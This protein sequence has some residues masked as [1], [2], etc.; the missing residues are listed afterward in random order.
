MANRRSAGSAVGPH[1][2]AA[3]TSGFYLVEIL[4]VITIISILIA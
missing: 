3:A 2:F 1:F 4:V